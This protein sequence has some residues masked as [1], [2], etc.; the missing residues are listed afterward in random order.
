MNQ[1]E[2][3]IHRFREQAGWQQCSPPPCAVSHLT[4]GLLSTHC[5]WGAPGPGH[6]GLGLE[7]SL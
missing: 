3:G 6:P 5:V 4:Q 2:A 1:A 7:L